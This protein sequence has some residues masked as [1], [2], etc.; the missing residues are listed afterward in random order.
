[1]K[2]EWTPTG[3]SKVT[4]GDDG[5]RHVIVLEA[6]GGAC[7]EQVSQLV[8]GSNPLRNHRGNVAG[9]FS[10]RSSK[11]YASYDAAAGEFL[12]LYDSLDAAGELLVTF[13]SETWAFAGAVLR[14]V[15]AVQMNGVFWTF[16]FNFGITTAV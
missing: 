4:L 10:F 14:A 6:V 3:G 5:S 13:S 15:Q 1:M 8:R 9:E 11:T 7:A 12:F 2:I 16:R